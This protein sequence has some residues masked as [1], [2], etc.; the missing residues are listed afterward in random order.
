MGQKGIEIVQEARMQIFCHW[1]THV[2]PI[3]VII[4][5]QS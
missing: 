2:V 3:C 5:K 1:C 4:N